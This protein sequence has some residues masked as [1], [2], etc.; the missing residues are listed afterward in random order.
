MDKEHIHNVLLIETIRAGI[1]TRELVGS[2]PDL[3]KNLMDKIDNDLK[4]LADG[5]DVK[6]RVIWGEYGQ[7]KTHFLKLIEKHILEKGYA[8]SYLTLNRDLGLNNLFNLFPALTS[9]VLTRD[10][11]IPGLINQLIDTRIS[12]LQY[13]ELSTLGSKISHPLPLMILLAFLNYDSANLQLLYNALM[14]KKENISQAKNIVKANNKHD[15]MNMPKFLQRD[16]LIAFIEFF[17]LL[18]KTLGNKGWVILLDELEI[19]GR[20][21]KISRLNSYKNLSWLM[22]LGRGH[23]LPIYTIAA[24]AGTLNDDV[25]RGAKKQDAKEMPKLA[26]ERF[27]AEAAQRIDEFFDTITGE[28][29]LVLQPIKD[30]DFLP[31]LEGLLAIHQK[32]IPWKHEPPRNF[33]VDTLKRI[34]PSSKKVRQVIRMFIETLDVYASYGEV[35]GNF[36]ENM[37]EI[38]DIDTELPDPPEDSLDEAKGYVET[39]LKDMFR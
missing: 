29:G 19:L 13:E 37:M 7:G 38:Y 18:L 28:Q 16:H 39:P 25:F 26:K 15:F 10:A 23:G 27:D 4:N 36:T 1:S 31:L 32:A 22:N 14:G 17:P 21:G 12:P 9:H 34:N 2:L 33:I 5:Q 11:N 24:S 6:G 35:P 30:H 8:V 20:L 3:R